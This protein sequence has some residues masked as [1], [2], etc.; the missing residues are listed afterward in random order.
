MFQ[1]LFSPAPWSANAVNWASLILRLTLG[2][3]MLTHGTPKLMKLISGDIQFPNPVG[4]GDSA[5]LTLTV[6]AEFLCSIFIILGLG[7]RLAL[8]PLIMTMV[9]VIGIIHSNDP[10]SE[11]EHALMFLMPYVT[12]FLMGSGKYSLDALIKSKE[13]DKTY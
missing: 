10:F 11:K 1:K 3:L 7:T 8:I 12:L 13:I 5:S 2:S 6:F 4:L 9:I